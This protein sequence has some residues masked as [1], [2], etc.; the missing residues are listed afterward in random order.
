MEPFTRSD[1][2]LSSNEWGSQ[3]IGKL[4]EWI[5]PDSPVPLVRRNSEMVIKQ[6]MAW[7]SHLGLP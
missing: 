1:K 5:T 3:V 6:E 2:L 4:S 7:A